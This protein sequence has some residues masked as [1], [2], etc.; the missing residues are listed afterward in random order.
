MEAVVAVVFHTYDPPPDAV[1]VLEL[2]LQIGLALADIAAGG[3]AFTVIE[4][5][6]VAVQPF[7]AVPVTV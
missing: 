6:A 3:K 1:R 2:P 7:A 4:R 5:V